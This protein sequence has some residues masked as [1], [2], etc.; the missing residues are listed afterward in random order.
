MTV[1]QQHMLRLN[2]K[3]E[4]TEQ[5]SAYNHKYIIMKYYNKKIEDLKV[6]MDWSA[7]QKKEN[8]LKN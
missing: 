5:F 7:K 8:F 1:A 3:H 4:K 6:A 2:K